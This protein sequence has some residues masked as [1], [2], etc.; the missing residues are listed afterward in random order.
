MQQ[1]RDV[2]AA[3]EKV[4]FPDLRT[5]WLPINTCELGVLAGR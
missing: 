4:R 1:L 2:S 5:G 3:L